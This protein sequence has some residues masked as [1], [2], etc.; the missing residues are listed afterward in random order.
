MGDPTQD[1]TVYIVHCTD[2][3]GPLYESVNASFQRLEDIFGLKIEPSKYNLEALQ[4]GDIDLG[5]LEQD[6]ARVL[7]PRLISYNDTWDKI[8]AMLDLITSDDF[9]LGYPDSD[10]LGWIYNWFCVDHVGYTVNPRRKDCGYHNIFDHYNALISDNKSSDGLHFHFHPSHPSG[11]S[12]KSATFYFH[13]LKFYQI[14]CRRIIERNWFPSV[15]SAGFQVERPD[16]HWLLEQW[17]PFDLSNMACDDVPD[18]QQDFG[19]GVSGDWRRAPNDWVVYNPSHD[20]YQ[21]Q[22]ECRRYIARCLNLGTRLGILDESELR[23]GFERARYHGATILAFADHDFRDMGANVLEFIEMLKKVAP[24]YPDVRFKYSEAR[25]AF[26]KSIFGEFLP[27]S[28]NILDLRLESILGSDKKRLLI[29]SSEPTFGPQPFLAIRTKSG[30]YHHDNLDFQ[31]P[32]RSWTYLFHSDTFEWQDVDT[33][34]IASND[35]K[36]FPHVI[37]KSMDDLVASVGYRV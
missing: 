28:R 27:P 3:E 16:S 2:T 8:N 35:S 15:N 20:D 9:R 23:K 10:G 25:E 31:V 6:V 34:G 7:D 33:V 32:K 5:G 19:G 18:A 22:G 24:E 36:G 30:H 21:I 14:L 12:H 13:D 4:K 29:D 17:I 37:V 1:H 26:S 11:W